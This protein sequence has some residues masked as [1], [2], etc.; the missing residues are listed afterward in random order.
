MGESGNCGLLREE[1]GE[2]GGVTAA[3]VDRELFRNSCISMV[4]YEKRK[5]GG[6]HVFI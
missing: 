6:N 2:A 1:I 5:G 3:L 4:Y